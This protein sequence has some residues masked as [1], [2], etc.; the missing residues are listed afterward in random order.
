[1]VASG[2]PEPVT[3]V[4][5]RYE[6]TLGLASAAAEAGLTQDE[7]A[8]RLRRSAELSRSLGALLARGGTVQRQVFQ[9]T[10]AEMARSF[11]L[12]A[13]KETTET[14]AALEPFAGHRGAVRGLAFSA[15]G[16]TVVTGGEDKT[17]RLWDAATGK[18]QAVWEGAGDEVLCLAISGDGSHVL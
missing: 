18:Q 2:E 13:E 5:W 10:F 15:D 8:A 14:V 11:R 3:A 16:R 6:T 4:A 12:G 9:D 7:F 1:G 17:V